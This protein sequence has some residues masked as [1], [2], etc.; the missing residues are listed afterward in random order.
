[1]DVNIHESRDFQIEPALEGLELRAGELGLWE[2]GAEESLRSGGPG[3]SPSDLAK[4]SEELSLVQRLA[5]ALCRPDNQPHIHITAILN[6]TASLKQRLDGI[7]A[8]Q[9][10][11]PLS[12]TESATLLSLRQAAIA[13]SALGDEAEKELHAEQ[14][15]LRGGASGLF[16]THVNRFEAPQSGLL[17][18]CETSLAELRALLAQLSG[19]EREEGQRLLNAGEARWA[20]LLQWTGET[21]AA[22]RKAQE[23]QE[24]LDAALAAFRQQKSEV[25]RRLV[26]A[27]EHTAKRRADRASTPLSS[28]DDAVAELSQNEALLAELLEAAESVERMKGLLGTLKPLMAAHEWAQ[29]N[30]TTIGLEFRLLEL[31][32]AISGLIASRRVLIE[33]VESINSY[34]TETERKLSTAVIPGEQLEELLRETRRKQST[35]EEAVQTDADPAGQHLLRQADRQLTLMTEA[36]S[37]RQEEELSATKAVLLCRRL[38]VLLVATNSKRRQIGQRQSLESQAEILGRKTELEAI[39]RE[40]R[41]EMEGMPELER[42]AG[43]LGEP[44]PLAMLE[45]IREGQRAGVSELSAAVGELSEAEALASVDLSV[46]EAWLRETRERVEQ[47]RWSPQADLEVADAVARVRSFSLLPTRY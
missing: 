19:R 5:E 8:G 34:V 31:K 28:V 1:M 40:L 6:R 4:W 33:R 45:Q 20:H 39:G 22:L 24:A 29:H 37:K 26:A 27:E 17:V 43:S 32:D 44:Q 9:L 11:A 25:E 41:E 16:T 47:L 3:P 2:E 35:L 14:G 42:E 38:E 15:E 7:Q 46:E 10:G 18:R 23:E 13:L 21:R 36:L 12:P 30:N